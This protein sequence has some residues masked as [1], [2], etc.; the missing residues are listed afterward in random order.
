MRPSAFAALLLAPALPAFLAC[1]GAEVA[2]CDPEPPTGEETPY[3]DVTATHLPAMT[4][5]GSMEARA[6]DVDG[7]GDLDL[8]IAKEF[9]PNVLLLNEGAGRFADASDRIPRTAFDSEDVA[10]VDLDRDGDT[11]LVVAAEDDQ[12]SELWLNDGTGRFGDASTRLPAAGTSNAVAAGDLDGDGD[13][14]LVFGNAGPELIFLNDGAGGLADASARLS[15]GSDVT[16]DAALGDVDGD[17]DLDLVTGNEG[18]GTRLY[19]NDGAAGF[20]EAVGAVAAPAAP[21]VTRNADL[22]DADGDGDLDLHLANVGSPGVQP[23]SRLLLNDGR[24]VFA[25]AL[26]RLP[27][28]GTAVFDG[29]FADLDGDGDRD[30]V[31]VGNPNAPAGRILRN[32]GGVFANV[33]F[34]LLPATARG[35]VEVEAADFDGDGRLDLYFTNYL[36]GDRLLLAP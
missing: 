27:S 36:E 31:Y 1:G 7:D 20:V 18:T 24:G 2:C 25:E 3:R 14:D 8:V 13:P 4:P 16:Q 10:A 12:R 35:S 17:G 22:G 23:R 30:L 15:S 28:V 21:E 9:L 5:R 26:D 33:S 6:V 19:L 34:L 11:D 32:A 29:D